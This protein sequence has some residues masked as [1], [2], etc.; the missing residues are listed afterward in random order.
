[1][2]ERMKLFDDEYWMKILTGFRHFHYASP[3]FVPILEKQVRL[4]R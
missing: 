3:G 4:K 1:M 2:I